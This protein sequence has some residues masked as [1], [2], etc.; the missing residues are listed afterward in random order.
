MKALTTTD[1]NAT[2]I[3]RGGD[4]RET[5]NISKQ[6]DR[7]RLTVR[8]YPGERVR[9]LC[10]E[11]IEKAEKAK[12]FSRV[13]KASLQNFD[14]SPKYKLFQHDVEDKSTLISPQDRHP[15]QKGKVYRCNSTPLVR[16]ESPQEVET[17]SSP[18]YYYDS[19]EKVL[20]FSIV[21]G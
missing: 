2:I 4:Y 5:I 14:N 18:A 9:L 17:M 12:G 11:K 7:Q 1:D 3:I 21:D 8:A 19:A 16:A 15:L 6:K 10:G 13:L 20:Y